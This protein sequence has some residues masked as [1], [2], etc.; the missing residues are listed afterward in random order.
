ME[1]IPSEVKLNEF[2]IYLPYED[3]INLCQTNIL[4][5][6]ICQRN[7]VWQ[8]LIERDFGI[9]YSGEDARNLYLLYKHALDKF[10]KYLPI[11]TQP[12][13]YILVN[14]IPVS[15]WDNM[16]ESLKEY[17]DEYIGGEYYPKIFSINILFNITI[18]GKYYNLLQEIADVRV[19][20]PNF[21][22]IIEELNKK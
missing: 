14:F 12:A 8:L 4:F 5:N 7:S 18:D 3:I 6:T 2:W 19:L 15:E 13:L 17:L 21:K 20:Y 9:K 22:Q 1:I 16:E 11:I 10:S